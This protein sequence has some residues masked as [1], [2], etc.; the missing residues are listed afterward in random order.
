MKVGEIGTIELQAWLCR[1]SP[2]AKFEIHVVGE[3]MAIISPGMASVETVNKN[4]HV[5]N[6]FTGMEKVPGCPACQWEELKWSKPAPVAGKTFEELVTQEDLT[7]L[8]EVK[9]SYEQD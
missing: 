4:P 8:K 5:H 3:R 9:V 7:W 2:G 6:H 1:Y